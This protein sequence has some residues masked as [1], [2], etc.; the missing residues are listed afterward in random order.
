MSIVVAYKFARDPADASVAPDGTVDWSRARPSISPDDAVALALA[1]QV[2]DASAAVLIAVTVGPA[3]VAVPQARKSALSR[4]PSRLLAVADDAL[5]DA[6][7]AWTAGLLAA[8]VRRVPDADLLV[9]GD[10][11]ADEAA[12]IVPSSSPT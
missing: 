1:R 6:D 10:A 11:S 8:L 2:A 5:T 3:A 9:A 7:A 12:G 4:G